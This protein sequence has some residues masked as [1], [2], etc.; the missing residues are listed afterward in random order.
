[1]LRRKQLL[2]Y[3]LFFVHGTE[4]L[5]VGFY[6]DYEMTAESSFALVNKEP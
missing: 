3:H 4:Y 5:L 6:Y 2:V 1:M